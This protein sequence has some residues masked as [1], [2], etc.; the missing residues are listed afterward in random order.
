MN[1][2][3]DFLARNEFT[4]DL[5]YKLFGVNPPTAYYF[6]VNDG[7]PQFGRTYIPLCLAILALLIL[8]CVFGL[9]NP[10]NLP[11]KSTKVT[12]SPLKGK[13]F[14]FL[15]SSITKGFA[16]YGKSFVDM[17]ADRNDAVCVK[18][19]VNGT[20]LVDKSDRSYISRLKKISPD[21][22]CDVFVCQLS[23]NDA[24]KNS[25]LGAVAEGKDRDSFDTKTVCG[26]IEYIIAYVKETWNCPVA[27]YTNPQYNNERYAAMVDA[28][29]SIAAKWDI[30]V[31]DLWH[32]EEINQKCKKRLYKNDSIHPTRKGYAAWTPVFE[33]ALSDILAGR[34]VAKGNAVALD[35]AKLKSKRIRHTIWQ[36]IKYALLIALAVIVAILM[37]GIRV[38]G[39]YS[40]RGLPGNDKIYN[41]SKLTAYENSPIEG[42][43]VLFLG[44]SVT[45]GY[46]GGNISFVDYIEKLDS[47]HAIKEVM[48][49][50]TVANITVGYAF[51]RNS[52]VSRLMKHDA[53][54]PVDCVVVQLSTNDAT[55]MANGLPV[56]ELSDSK[57][58]ED[59]DDTTFVGGMEKII[60]YSYQTWGCPVVVYSNANPR[61]DYAIYE[62]MI[63][64]TRM[65][66]DKW[67]ATFLDL[68]NDE[69]FNNQVS[70]EQFNFYMTNATHP[71]KAGY[72][73]WW[74]PAFEECL[75]ELI[76]NK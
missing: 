54:E 8:V 60:A 20:T 14:I 34:E 25:P 37:C 71:N 1:A 18:E 31:I 7:L 75:Y 74:T 4:S 66:T 49:G 45:Q 67:G 68:Y 62:D 10:G 41:P 61:F 30:Q 50:T 33:Q 47:V 6:A 16:S 3:I 27:F 17:I 76:G 59:I 13:N 12:D 55:N 58:I 46:G 29:G 72:L 19:A 43:T 70:D 36:F 63:E 39:L 2:L 9:L 11:K 38:F 22:P 44:S 35:P 57:N 65:V 15:G 69:E 73:E 24:A 23:T 5:F 42:K 32:N 56:G 52:Y 28:L 53:S 40:G 21:T 64:L 51:D 26:A 48:G